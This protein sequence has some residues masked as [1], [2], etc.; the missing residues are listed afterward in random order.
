[1][2][3]NKLWCLL[4]FSISASVTASEY[5]GTYST[6]AYPD[7]ICEAVS[8]YP[9]SKLGVDSGFEVKDLL[10]SMNAAKSSMEKEAV[11]NGMDAI[12]GY[13]SNYQIIVTGNRA[14]IAYELNGV[15]V[16]LLCKK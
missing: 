12:I 6:D 8:W 9:T 2:K 5:K 3:A 11:K 10:I 7:S 14:V 13:D 15:A 4:P 1:M 16:K